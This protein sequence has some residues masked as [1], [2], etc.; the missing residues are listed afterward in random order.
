MNRTIAGVRSEHGWARNVVLATAFVA[1][2][3]VVGVVWL[4]RLVTFEQHIGYFAPAFS[5]DGRSAFLVER[6]TSGISW[7]LGWE[8]FTPPASVRAFSDT[9]RLQ[10]LDLASGNVS[11]LET[12]NG[13]PIVGHTLPQYRGRLFN[14]LSVALRPRPDAAVE[15]ALELA[16]PRVPTAEVHQLRGVWA[17]DTRRQR[18]E[19]DTAPFA[20]VGASEPVI[21]GAR[22]LFALPG[23]ESFPAALALLDHSDRSIHVL[24]RGPAYARQYPDGPALETLMTVSRKADYD[25]V[26]QM[27]RIKAERV[28]AYRAQGLSEGEALLRAGRDLRDLGFYPK[29]QRWVATVPDAAQLPTYAKLAR[30]DLDEMETKVGLFPDLERAMAAP[31]TEVDKG[32]SRYIRHRDYA[33]SERLNA[34]LDAGTRELLIAHGGRVY[35]F[36]LLPQENATRRAGR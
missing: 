7:G 28:A 19:W 36:Q 3:I 23:P 8:F 17:G 35:H 13:S 27:N 6:T 15:Y 22:E 14:H 5:A 18:G 4:L 33:N 2:F 12:W 25:H 29:P 9:V 20:A 16:L 26:Q 34:L 24:L 21:D 11:T 10:Q 1:L 32:F 30:L 31:G